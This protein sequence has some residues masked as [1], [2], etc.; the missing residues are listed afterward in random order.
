MNSAD[1]PWG[2]SPPTAP[3]GTAPRLG[4]LAAAS[5]VG[6]PPEAP[7]PARRISGCAW[8]GIGVGLAVFVGIA[9]FIAAVLVGDG[10]DRPPA[11]RTAVGQLEVGTCVQVPRGALVPSS[12]ATES[13]AAPHEGE[14]YAV[15]RLEAGA[16][17]GEAAAQATAARRCLDRFEP[18][19]GRAYEESALEVT[20]ASPTEDRWV[21]EDRSFACIL[22][23]V[24]GADL[25]AGSVR[26]S[27]R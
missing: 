7:R 19:V 3:P 13:C 26:G 4:S 22:H 1:P 17:P 11:G 9:A 27:G 23:L 24:D 12:M 8:A 6:G 14:V 15:G 2:V 21:D 25:P 18:F 5:V 16:F 10:G 20:V